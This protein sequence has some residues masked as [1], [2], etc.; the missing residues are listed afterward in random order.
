MSH[1]WNMVSLCFENDQGHGAFNIIGNLREIHRQHLVWLPTL[2]HVLHVRNVLICSDAPSDP[3]PLLE[4][5]PLQ[6]FHLKQGTKQNKALTATEASECK[7]LINACCVGD[8]HG[9]S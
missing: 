4:A 3:T 2:T 6:Q 8:E 1:F 9:H 5:T 7:V